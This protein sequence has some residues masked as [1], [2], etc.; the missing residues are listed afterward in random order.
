MERSMFLSVKCFIMRCG[1]RWWL[2]RFL[3]AAMLSKAQA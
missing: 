2:P 1:G 3:L